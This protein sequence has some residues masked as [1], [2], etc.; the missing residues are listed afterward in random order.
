MFSPGDVLVQKFGGSSMA[1][2]ERILKVA[3]RIAEQARGGKPMAIV[4]SAM[5]DTTDDLIGL[6]RQIHVDP[7]PMEMDQLMATGEMVSCCLMASALQKLGL[8]AR[9]YNAF[10]L[11]IMTDDHFG[12]AEIMKFGRIQELSRFIASPGVAVVAGFQGMTPD[13][14]LTTL[15]RGGSD[16]T[17]VALARELGQR[18][19]EKY[20]DEDGIYSA[21]P[22]LIPEARKVWHLNYAEMETLA[23]YGNGILHPRSIACAR[24]FSIRIHVR[25]SFSK[26]E[27]SIIGPLGNPDLPVK[28][29][30]CDK[31][32]AIVSI[33]GIA[34]DTTLSEFRASCEDFFPM[35]LEETISAEKKVMRIGFKINDSFQALPFFWNQADRYQAEDVYFMARVVVVSIVGEGLAIDRSIKDRFLHLLEISN[36]RA[37]LIEF[38]NNRLSVAVEEEHFEKMVF[39]WHAALLALS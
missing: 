3:E 16:I 5:G 6:M 29:L 38:Q 27:G 13:R 23:R 34:K 18:V 4:V 25:S 22:R 33:K 11:D 19:C 20:T 9:S 36:I 26:D 39:L 31:K 12:S 17:A 14:D 37:E 28:S 2:P 7:D 24:D 8:K 35:E 10:N 21:D 32:Q 1:S 30:T 15:G